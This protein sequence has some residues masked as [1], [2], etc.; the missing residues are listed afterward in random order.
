VTFKDLQKLVQSLSSPEQSQLLQRL[1]DKPFW[2]WDQD[3]HRN[4][5]IRTKGGCCLNHI[6][7][8][9]RKDGKIEKP[10]FDYEK[11]LYDSLLIPDFY[12]PL[13]FTFKHKHLWVKKAT[14][15]GVTEF[16]LRFMAWLCLRSD[17]YRNSQMC[18]VTG[19]NQE[20]AIKLIERMK[21]LFEEKLGITKRSWS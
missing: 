2:I 8:L 20:L 1:R 18:I 6:I 9:P 5:D 19:P 16:F 14:G 4:E 13:Q 15:L 11:L 21:L 12:N 3:S 7:G 10:M 17:D